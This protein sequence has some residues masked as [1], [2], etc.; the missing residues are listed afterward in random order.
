MMT[1]HPGTR[2]RRVMVLVVLVALALPALAW[3][4]DVPALIAR[5]RDGKASVRQQAAEQLG[6]WADKRAVSPLIE[7]LRDRDPSVRQ[8]AVYALSLTPDNRVTGAL[9]TVAR[10]ERNG[11]VRGWAIQAL[12]ES[13]DPHVA[14]TLLAILAAGAGENDDDTVQALMQL[15]PKIVSPLLNA[16]QSANPHLRAGTAVALGRSP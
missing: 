3:Q 11:T 10:N 7:L 16:L 4:D 2:F 6:G 14:P 9:T 15:S 5:L 8:A 12:G 1:E 13:N